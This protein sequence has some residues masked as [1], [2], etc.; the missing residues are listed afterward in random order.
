MI[1]NQGDQFGHSVA[2]T[3]GNVWVGAKGVD[4]DPANPPS[5]FVDSGQATTF[6]LD[7]QPPIPPKP[8]QLKRY[9][10]AFNLGEQ[11]ADI[12]PP[13]GVID[14]ADLQEYLRRMR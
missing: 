7:C 4:V 1:G 8:H 9:L 5:P 10:K 11:P 6:D 2:I 14:Q 12:A 3:G 13:F